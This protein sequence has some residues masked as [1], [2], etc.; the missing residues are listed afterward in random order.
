MNILSLF[1]GI[2]CARIAAERAGIS[3][4]NYYAAEIDKHAK[5]IAQ[6]N[7]P[8]TVQLGDVRSITAEIIPHK[9]D[10]MVAGPPCQDL[11]ALNKNGKGLEGE[12]S[13]LFFEFI[14]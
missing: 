13:G 11:S 14:R 6:A 7:Y 3:V 8:D 1:D 2:S 5:K 4:E 12:K 10:L 9:I